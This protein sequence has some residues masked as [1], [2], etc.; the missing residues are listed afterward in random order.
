[1]TPVPLRASLA[2]AIGLAS[3][4]PSLASAAEPTVTLEEL[5][6]QVREQQ[7]QLDALAAQLDEAPS[8]S[9]TT[10]GG[11]GELHYNAL[12]S[13]KEIDF[14]RFVLFVGHEFNDRIRLFSEFELEHALAGEGKKGEVELEQAYIEFL[15]GADT[16]VKGGLFLVPVGFLNETHE[17]TTFYGVERNPVENAIIPTTWWEAGAMVSAP[18]GGV[19]SGFS[20]DFGL[21]SGLYVTNTFNIRSGR[22]KVSEAKADELATTARL[23]WQGEGLELGASVYYQDDIS[24]G[25]VPGAGAGTLVEMH[26]GLVV[27]QFAFK[28]LGAQWLLDGPAPEALQKDEQQGAYL[29]GA[30]RPGG[31]WGAFVRYAEWDNGGIGATERSQVNAGINWWPHENVVIKFD[32]QDQGKSVGDDG[33]NL[34]IGYRF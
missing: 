12:D 28:A 31:S 5:Q 11:Y 14:H 32:V 1:M 16:R 30:W 13:K 15:V 6:R 10:I 4:A 29:E 21:H 8:A 2:F 20:Y 24:Q 26:A 34:G 33:F 27:G 7:A 3:F 9:R 25:L 18:L 19:D 22:Q 23:R 17:P